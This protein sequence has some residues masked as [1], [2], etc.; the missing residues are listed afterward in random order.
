MH[1][2]NLFPSQHQLYNTF[3]QQVLEDCPPP[4]PHLSM[5]SIVTWG[6]YMTQYGLCAFYTCMY[7]GD[8][9][10]Y[11]YTTNKGYII[12]NYTNKLNYPCK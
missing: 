4:N 1:L 5:N 2:R 8:S 12:L 3:R 6:L 9:L 10:I 7:G 11:Y